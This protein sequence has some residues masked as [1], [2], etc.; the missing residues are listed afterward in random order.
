MSDKIVQAINEVLIHTSDPDRAHL[1]PDIIEEIAN[2]I[3]SF[4]MKGVGNL[5]PV[6]DLL[7][8]AHADGKYPAS[9][10]QGHGDNLRDYT[11]RMAAM[12]MGPKLV[13]RDGTGKIQ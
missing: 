4:L 2:K 10:P 9:T 5:N 7:A 13:T 1:D 3:A 6:Y 12:F 11:N 8:Q